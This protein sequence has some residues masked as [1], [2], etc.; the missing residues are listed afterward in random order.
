MASCCTIFS[1]RGVTFFQ[2][3]NAPVHRTR[4]TVTYKTQNHIPSLTWP[5]QSPDLNIIENLWVFTK[6]KLQ[7]R[8]N[9]INSSAKLFQDIQKIW[10]N[11]TPKYVQSLYTSI[12]RRSNYAG[13]SIKM[14]SN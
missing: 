12:T 7:S 13:Y 9:N 8:K 10:K 2:D 4:S 5:A 6:R 14:P 3:D 11:I 1:S